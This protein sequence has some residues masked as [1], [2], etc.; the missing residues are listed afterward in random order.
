MVALT[1][2][3]LGMARQDY[4]AAKDLGS[5]TC[6][7]RGLVDAA[8]GLEELTGLPAVESLA[9]DRYDQRVF[10]A[11]PWLEIYWTDSERRHGMDEAAAEYERCSS[12]VRP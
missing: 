10:L 1:R 12:P 6:F 9:G 3:A 11:P 5:W 8:V 2:R 7:D 4:V